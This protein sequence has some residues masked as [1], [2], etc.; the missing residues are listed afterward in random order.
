MDKEL[1]FAHG[2]EGTGAEGLCREYTIAP[3][4]CLP[5]TKGGAVA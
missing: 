3:M 5:I 1:F 2:A 4:R